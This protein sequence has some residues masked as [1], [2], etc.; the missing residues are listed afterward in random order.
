[1]KKIVV[2]MLGAVAIANIPLDSIAAAKC[3]VEQ[4]KV[5]QATRERLKSESV[6]ERLT[7][8]ITNRSNRGDEQ[9]ARLEANV[10][11]A[12]GMIQGGT[13][14]LAGDALACWLSQQRN[15]SSRTA[16]NAARRYASAVARLEKAKG[17]LAAFK[18]SL[19]RVLD[20]LTVRLRRASDQV[21]AKQLKQKEAE[22]AL[23]ACMG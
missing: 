18:V 2:V 9:I 7:N 12:D 17:T 19:A 11:Q 14:N 6:V 4:R 5:T 16:Q 23:K 15:C 1:M 10:S 8:D 13:I 21:V 20:T 22:D 3:T